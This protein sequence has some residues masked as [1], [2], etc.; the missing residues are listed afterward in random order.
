MFDYYCTLIQMHFAELC[1]LY[2]FGCFCF[3]GGKY[4]KQVLLLYRE[5]GNQDFLI[6]LCRINA[7]AN[8]I[9]EAILF[10]PLLIPQWSVALGDDP[11]DAL[12]R[13]YF[14]EDAFELLT[15]IHLSFFDQINDILYRCIPQYAQSLV[16]RKF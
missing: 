16:E 7:A 6:D 11:R 4:P 14:F 3:I 2:D 10:S 9:I 15:G 13:H 1:Y 12:L 8:R 5:E